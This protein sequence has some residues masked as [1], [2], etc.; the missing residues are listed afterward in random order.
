MVFDLDIL[1]AFNE[2]NVLTVFENIAP[3]LNFAGEDFGLSSNRAEA[4]AQFQQQ[5]TSAAILNAINENGGQDARYG[6]PTT[7]QG[8]RQVRFGFRLLF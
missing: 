1:N 3:G 2:S 6:Q 7:F 8:G 4:E 5:N